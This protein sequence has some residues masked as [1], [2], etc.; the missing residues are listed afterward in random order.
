MSY[1]HIIGPILGSLKFLQALCG[2]IGARYRARKGGKHL[3]QYFI[4]SLSLVMVYSKDDIKNV[5]LKNKIL[6]LLLICYKIHY[7]DL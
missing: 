5:V 7:P 1:F 4:L 3:F 6:D 2:Q